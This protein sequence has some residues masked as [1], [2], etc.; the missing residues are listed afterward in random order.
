MVAKA[1]IPSTR[2]VSRCSALFFDLA[3]TQGSNDLRLQTKLILEASCKIA[4]TALAIIGHVWNL[5]D[6]IEHV[7]A[8]EEKDGNQ[9]DGSPEVA[10]LNDWQN[11]WCGDGK[12]GDDTEHG[13][14]CHGDL[15]V[16]DRSDERWMGT[17]GE[18]S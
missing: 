8:C 4:D 1:R 12:E 6:M 15:D 11:I 17:V 9:A 2:M 13:G 3:L 5:S 10:I 7:A 16:L 14:G 18:L